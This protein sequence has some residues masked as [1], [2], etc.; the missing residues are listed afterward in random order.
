[1][2]EHG[3]LLEQMYREVLQPYRDRID[4]K[5]AE[6]AASQ[7]NRHIREMVSYALEGGRRFRPLLFIIVC[8]LLGREP[9]E[10]VY[11]LASAME[12][13]HKASLLHDDLVDGDRF[14]RGRETFHEKFGYEQAVVVGDLLVAEASIRF[15][16]NAAPELIGSWLEQYR[17]LCFG[18]AMDVIGF[19]GVQGA[20]GGLR[21]LI[22]DIIYGKTASFMEFVFSVAAYTAGASDEQ[23]TLLAGFG[24]HLGFMFQIIND[25][26]NWSGLE[27][28]LGRAEGSDLSQ[29]RANHV[30]FLARV[31]RH[32]R[33]EVE[34]L[35]KEIVEAHDASA[36]EALR[37]LGIRNQY[38]FILNE[39][40]DGKYNEWYWG[41]ENS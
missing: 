40:L 17:K 5:L 22:D 30:T 18:E 26:N 4:E 10:R 23:R 34:R 35:V 25:L 15:Y 39:I 32:D 36:R 37:R 8:K 33:A 31:G 16:R 2:G 19:R 21:K 13:L 9:D 1:M 7:E 29:G 27:A 28:G 6:V 41:S 3:L 38:T 20:D 12:I 14:R 11:S 24:R